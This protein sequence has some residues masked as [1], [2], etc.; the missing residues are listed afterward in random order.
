[1]M[2]KVPKRLGFFA[3]IRN[4]LDSVLERDPAAR[5]RLEVFLV[6]PGLHA[7]WIHRI[8][9]WLWTHNSNCSGAG[10]PRLPAT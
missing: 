10:S 3:S 8:T 4:D 9:H 1:L 2:V 6:Y 7:I 5:S